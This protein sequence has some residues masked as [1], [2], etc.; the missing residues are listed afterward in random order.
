MYLSHVQFINSTHTWLIISNISVAASLAVPTLA[1]S[2]EP[3]TNTRE[4]TLEIS[5]A[6]RGKKI[7]T[8]Y[9]Q[10]HTGS[11]VG[12]HMFACPISYM[13]D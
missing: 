2:F 7:H 3:P 1:M 8:F 5:P 6:Y 13:T 12:K 4:D 10:A 11:P 9:L